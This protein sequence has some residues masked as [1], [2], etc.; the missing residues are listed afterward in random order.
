MWVSGQRHAVA[1]LPPGKRSGTCYI[2]GWVAPRPVWTGVENLAPIGIRSL[3]LPAHS[4]SLYRLRNLG[5]ERGKYWQK[6]IYPL[7]KL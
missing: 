1:N 3:D 6:F 7:S 4:K 5:F 2:G